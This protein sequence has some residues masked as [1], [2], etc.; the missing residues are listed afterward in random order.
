[1]LSFLSVEK[2]SDKKFFFPIQRLG[3]RIIGFWP[4]S[5]NIT[6]LQIFIAVF[7]ALEILV[8]SFFQ[9]NFCFLNRGKLIVVLDALTPLATQFTS[10]LK[11][12]YI[13]WWRR[14]IKQILDF[15]RDAFDNGKKEY[16]KKFKV[17]RGKKS[18]AKVFKLNWK[19]FR[20]FPRTFFVKTKLKKFFFLIQIERKNT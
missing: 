2:F 19:L 12:L 1:M 8:Y 10:G 3:W 9:F 17:L 16:Q 4:G 7:N 13:V 11:I 18:Q 14:E 6:K 15:L 20:V 5:D